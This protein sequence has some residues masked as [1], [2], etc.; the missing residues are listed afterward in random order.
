MNVVVPCCGT[1]LTLPE[2]RFEATVGFARFEVSAMNWSRSAWELCDE[3]LAAAGDILG[4]PVT[5]IHTQY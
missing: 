3:E 2:L 1:T 5:Q 4:H